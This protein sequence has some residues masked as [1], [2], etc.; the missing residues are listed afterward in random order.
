MPYPL[1]YYKSI[2]CVIN[3]SGSSS[4]VVHFM[5]NKDTPEGTLYWNYDQSSDE[6]FHVK[7]PRKNINVKKY[8]LYDEI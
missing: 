5:P 2:L 7:G 4:M 3:G 1:L 6:R 8:I